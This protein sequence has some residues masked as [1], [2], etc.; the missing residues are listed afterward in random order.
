MAGHVTP[1]KKEFPHPF[2]LA[3]RYLRADF[4]TEFAYQGFL[5]C[6]AKGDMAPERQSRRHSPAFEGEPGRAFYTDTGHTVRKT[7][8]PPF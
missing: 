4:L 2:Q 1:P 6:F 5:I 7:H 8:I 3:D